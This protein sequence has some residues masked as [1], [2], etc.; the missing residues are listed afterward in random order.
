MISLTALTAV[1]HAQDL[2]Q[3]ELQFTPSGSAEKNAGVWV[4]GHYLGYVKELK[5]MKKVLLLPGTHEIVVRQAWYKEYVE[6]ILFEPGTVHN[7]RL[8]MVKIPRTQ[9][10]DATAELKIC[11]I[12]TRAA[13]FVDDQFAG[14]SDE[15]GGAGQAMLITPG[16]H[17]LRNL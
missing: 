14:H 15:F 17:K 7:M 3:A 12:P 2:A 9:T 16:Q 10:T 4:D 8:S 6:Q 1:L 13:V 11:A 5:G